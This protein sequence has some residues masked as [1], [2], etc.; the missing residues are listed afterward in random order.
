[1]DGEIRKHA[2]LYITETRIEGERIIAVVR[3]VLMLPILAFAIIILAEAVNESGW[4][5]ALSAATFWFELLF[6][7][8]AG[9][10]SIITLRRTRRQQYARWM[11][12]V[13]PLVDVLLV[14]AT[15]VVIADPTTGFMVTAATP[16]LY[17]IF[18]ILCVLRSSPLSVIITGIAISLTHLALS[19]ITLS[20]LGILDP[21]FQSDHFVSLLHK[22][23]IRLCLDD[24][25]IKSFILLMLT[26]LLAY[27]AKRFN[28]MIENQVSI[29]LDRES[30]S[31]TLSR[32]LKSLT[33]TVSSNST[34]LVSTSVQFTRTVDT[35]VD[36]CGKIEYA[37]NE[38]TAAVEETSATITEMIHSIES[39]AKNIVKQSELV[40][41]SV[42]AIEEIGASITH[43]TATAKKANGLAAS[44]LSNAENGEQIMEEV[45][46]A[47]RETERASKSIEEIVEIISSIASETDLLAMNAAIEAAHAGEVGKGFAIVADEIRN[48]AETSGSNAKMIT[49]ILKDL[50]AR[51]QTI[52]DLVGKTA[53]ALFN[54]L[55]DAR[56]SSAIS[57]E[58]LNA[59]EEESRAVTDIVRS[60]QELARITDEVKMAS[61][62]Q[63]AGGTQIISVITH[64]KKQT[65]DVSGLT[66]GQIEKSHQIESIAKELN[67]VVNRNQSVISNLNLLVKKL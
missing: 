66:K 50:S 42:T 16:W 1:M 38:E 43:I 37:I 52:V 58:V 32:D 53:D 27:V 12:I 34:V 31:Q 19:L 59:M 64:I 14:T 47:M 28:K 45:S 11:N 15:L 67:E 20:Y 2:Q 44:L 40:G 41:S 49:S 56:E 46:G 51:I 30:L 57:S 55:K 24:V 13:L 21:G 54:I 25:I 62:E 36:A 3:L 26:G 29:R 22:H 17:I 65:D 60:T 10:V 63:A 33:E 61:T 35:M 5:I 18:L 23:M 6:L 39:V 4:E 48:L 9:I 7:L 8:C